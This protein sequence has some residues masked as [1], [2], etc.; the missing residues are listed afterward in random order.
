M[1]LSKAKTAELV[2]SFLITVCIIHLAGCAMTSV[3]QTS[4]MGPAA[5]GDTQ[6]VK[7]LIAQGAPVNGQERGITP[8]AVAAIGGHLATVAALL[9]GGAD[10]NAKLDQG[11]TALLV[12]TRKGS[13]EIVRL[14]VASGADVRARN[15]NGETAH[16]LP[17]G[18]AMP[19]WLR[20][21]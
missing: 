13:V 14:L 15:D 11:N 12:A 4:L 17:H 20:C 18:R 9:H 1:P 3:N 19:A 5:A 21:F 10:V 7:E 8:L 16:S 2:Y 6:R